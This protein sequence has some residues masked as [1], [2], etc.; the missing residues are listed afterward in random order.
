MLSS[1]CSLLLSAFPA[2]PGEEVAL[3]GEGS[4]V[5]GVASLLG[6]GGPGEGDFEDGQE[7][8]LPDSEQSLFSGFPDINNLLLGHVD[9]HVEALDLAAYDL[10]DPQGLVHE[11]LGGLDGHEGLVFSEEESE[12]AGD[13]LACMGTDVP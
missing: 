12:G 10:G 6:G 11:S 5:S 9:D 8:L 4:V 13:V 2:L 1:L 7:P 3:D